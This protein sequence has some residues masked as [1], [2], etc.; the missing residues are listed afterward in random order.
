MAALKV[1]TFHPYMVYDERVSNILSLP[2]QQLR[3]TV[4]VAAR[5]KAAAVEFC[6]Q[7][8]CSNPGQSELRLA[9]GGALGDAL[10]EA[11]LLN[12]EGV[13]LV[14][15]DRGG[16]KPLVL[17]STEEGAQAIGIVRPVGLGSRYV[18]EACRA[19][20]AGIGSVAVGKWHAYIKAAVTA[21][22]SYWECNTGETLSDEEMQRLID[23]NEVEIIRSGFGKWA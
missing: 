22:R 3:Y 18:F 2:R 5:S 12:D 21:D 11:S 13:V 1:Y 14:T 20:Y 23:L 15:A 10:W 4:F 16:E 19:A 6:K 7:A 17:M 9:S 8:G